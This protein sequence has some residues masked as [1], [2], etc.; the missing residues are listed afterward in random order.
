M[1]SDLK[2]RSAIVT[3]GAGGIGKQTAIRLAQAGASVCISDVSETAIASALKE[4]EELGL[5][6]IGFLADITN[7]S[8]VA[9]MVTLCKETFGSVD[10]LV[11]CAGIY[12]DRYFK[13]MTE[14]EWNQTLDINLGGVY[15]CCREVVN[16]MIENGYGRII[17]L[18]SQAGISG[19]VMHSHYAASKAAI[20]GL[21]CSLAKELAEYGINVNCVA[22]G[23]IE[24]EMTSRY[25]PERVAHFNS[26]IPLSRFGKPD[27]V[28]KV[29]AFL[30]SEDSSYMTGQTINVTGGWL[31]HS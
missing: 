27:E 10:I 12:K 8:K 30:A 5:N 17:T 19:S 15:N 3:G 21:T 14:A 13:D 31:M 23:I 16:V 29:I 25:T 6:A 24:T 4:S 7:R 28:A 2:G 26:L 11:N 20:V 18:T 22:P 1:Y 9:E